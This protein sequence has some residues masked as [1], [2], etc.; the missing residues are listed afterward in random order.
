MV[1]EHLIVVFHQ[2]LL[3]CRIVPEPPA[4][5]E[6]TLQKIHSDSMVVSWQPPRPSHGVITAYEISHSPVTGDSHPWL[7]TVSDQTLQ[8]CIK[9][10]EINKSYKVQVGSLLSLVPVYVT[11]SQYTSLSGPCLCYHVTVHFS[12]WFLSTLPCHSTLLS[13]VPVYVTMSQYTSLSGPCLCYHVTV[14]FSLWSL[15][16]L[17]CHSTLLSLVPVYVTMSQYTSLSGPCLCYHVTVHFHKRC[18]Y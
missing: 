10:L 1:D 7:I 4:P 9:H 6:V 18:W 12:L 5:R 16:M 15:S 3:Q 17:P 14:H 8:H 11:M 2:M 13:L